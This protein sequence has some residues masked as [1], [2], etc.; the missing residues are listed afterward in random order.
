MRSLHI[1]REGATDEAGPAGGPHTE[2]IAGRV[3]PDHPSVDRDG[4]PEPSG[5]GRPELHDEGRGTR[6]I[7][8]TRPQVRTTVPSSDP[9]ARPSPYESGLAAVARHDVHIERVWPM[10]SPPTASLEES[11]SAYFQSERRG[12]P[13]A[14][15]VPVGGLRMSQAF[16]HEPVM[17]DEVVEL[18][19]PVPPG[20]IVDAT[21]GGGG[22]AAALL[23]NI[24]GISLLGLD[25]DPLAVAAATDELRA[26]GS[27]AAV[28]RSRFDAV[29]DVVE[30]FE[31]D[32]GTPLAQRGLSGVLFDLGV[33]SPQLDVAERGFSYR[34]DAPLD[35]RMDPTSGPSAAD[36]VNQLDEDSLVELLTDNGEGRFAR[37][38]ARAMIEA[39]PLTTTGQL[40][41]VVRSAIPA[42]TRRTGGH[43]ARRVFQGIRIAVNDE[44]GQ[45]Q[46]ALDDAL[47]LLRPGGGASPSP[48]TPGRTGW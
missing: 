21:V 2:R 32:R 34:R 4:S 13:P 40:A 23:R 29:A 15:L 47:S 7:T 43:P 44:L 27:R 1:V 18:F 35:M 48:T 42:A 22:H 39:R 10:R 37:R 16:P 5:A 14:R 38:I 25:R 17:A 3:S 36:L 8:I 31:A 12:T 11:S 24:D 45:L 33:S 6:T 26:F 19:S 9:A 20:L 28:V 46:T 41:D 30:R